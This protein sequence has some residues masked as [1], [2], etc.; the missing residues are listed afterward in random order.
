[1]QPIALFITTTYPSHI[2]E[3]HCP[4][5]KWFGRKLGRVAVEGQQIYKRAC[6]FPSN[7][8]PSATYEK[9]L[10]IG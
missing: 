6:S 1:M 9:E 7:H 3:D 5:Y 2:E 4:I 10:L 8:I